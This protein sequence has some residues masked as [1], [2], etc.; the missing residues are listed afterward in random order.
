LTSSVARDACR[1]KSSPS[2][3]LIG[4]QTV[5]ILLAYQ[6]GWPPGATRARSGGH[7]PDGHAPLVRAQ[8]VDLDEGETLRQPVAGALGPLHHRD[9]TRRGDHLL[10]ADVTELL[11][12]VEPVKIEMIEGDVLTGREC[13]RVLVH[14]REGR[15]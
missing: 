12:I 11:R 1:S 4:G 6:T 5:N 10:P 15:A 8:V 7:A 3:S 2:S 13:C 9:P 14:E